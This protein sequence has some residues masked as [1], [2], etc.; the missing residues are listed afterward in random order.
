MRHRRSL[1]RWLAIPGLMALGAVIVL[2]LSGHLSLDTIA[3]DRR[4]VLAPSSSR[5]S[6]V[7][8]RPGSASPPPAT[9]QSETEQDIARYY[10]AVEQ[11]PNNTTALTLLGFAYLQNVREVGDPGDYARAEAAFD[12]ALE[13]DPQATGANLGKAQLAL[14]RHDF[15]TA[16]TLGEQVLARESS[17]TIAWG[18]LS[19]AQTE[20]GMYDEAL[21]SVQTMVDTRPDLS[22]YSRVSYQR[23]LHGQIDGAI[24]AMEAAFG[25]PSRNLEND[26]Y[27]RVLIANLHFLKGDLQGAEEIYQASLEVYPDFV[28]ALAGQ[29]RVHAARGEYE[30]GIAL[31]QQAVDRIPLPEFVI[32]LG[33]LQE[34]AGHTDD[35]AATYELV[36]VIQELFTSNGV[37]TDLE[38]ALFNANHGDDPQAAVAL[39]RSAYEVQPNVKAADALGWALY[40]AGELDEA[41]QYAEEALRLGTHDGSFL[42][43]AGMIAKEQGDK[44]AAR[45]YLS[46]ALELNPYFS[47]LYAPVAREALSE[48]GGRVP[49]PAP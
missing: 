42:F 8:P 10:Q 18:V 30:E 46:R 3:G 2:A 35:A 43:H 5:P 14:A 1:M 41:R 38:L 33:E 7:P 44:E 48:V 22:S 39:A 12:E 40:K 9:G 20:L 24:E 21:E 27:I 17:N 36:R 4:D 6:V 16:L 29:A 28:W 34:A 45:D 47:P 11:D 23:E 15:R 32:A 37:N 49:S 25:A 19:D 13:L 26:E 31:Y